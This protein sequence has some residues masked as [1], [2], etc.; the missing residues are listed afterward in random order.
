MVL[1]IDHSTLTP[2]PHEVNVTD[3]EGS[4]GNAVLTIAERALYLSPEE[5]RAGSIITVIGSG[6][7]AANNDIG[8]EATPSV[9]IKYT[10]GTTTD[11]VASIT[12][13]GQGN[14][15]GIFTVPLF[16]DVPSTNIV[17][18]ELEF[19][20]TGGTSTTLVTSATHVVL[21]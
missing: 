16:V 9:L 5:S 20:P 17:T 18:A 11:T 1:P 4:E 12:A 7:P 19:T 21:P 13:D 8:A 15:S 14:I 6:Y 2:G 3:N 10:C